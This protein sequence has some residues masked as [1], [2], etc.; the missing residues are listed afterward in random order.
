MAHP[1]F[2]TKTRWVPGKDASGWVKG[3]EAIMGKAA[4]KEKAY[5]AAHDVKSGWAKNKSNKFKKELGDWDRMKQIAEQKYVQGQDAVKYEKATQ[6]Y[7]Q[8][9][10]TEGYNEE[11]QTTNPLWAAMFKPTGR[12][13]SGD[14]T[15]N[16]EIAPRPSKDN[17]V[18]P[19]DKELGRPTPA[20]GGTYNKSDDRTYVDTT[21]TGIH[22]TER[23]GPGTKNPDGTP[24]TAIGE[25]RPEGSG[26]VR[27]ADAPGRGGPVSTVRA[28][29]TTTA[30][31]EDGIKGNLYD[32]TNGKGN[33]ST[34]PPTGPR[35]SP[36]E[37]PRATGSGQNLLDAAMVRPSG[38]IVNAPKAAPAPSP[39]PTPPPKA[40]PSEEPWSWSPKDAVANTPKV[41]PKVAPAP[42]PAPKAAPVERTRPEGS[43]RTAPAPKSSNTVKAVTSPAIEKAQNN[44]DSV[45]K[46]GKGVSGTP[47]KPMT[48]DRK[49]ITKPAPKP[50]PKPAQTGP[51]SPFDPAY[52]SPAKDGK[53]VI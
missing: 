6:G 29:A 23:E 37:R 10:G 8:D 12:P 46:D 27:P 48:A 26:R 44:L 49:P 1:Q 50:A 15:W 52:T 36:S 53:A 40:A 18:A 51:L 9:K 39:R 35:T 31:G 13:V 2:L 41:A 14:T 3:K 7:F 47:T 38:K 42:A 33:P 43:G 11:Y 45:F 4:I 25:K 17:Y 24:K 19:E 28:N 21:E 22:L 34:P 20:G 32:R 30:I 5:K 16:D